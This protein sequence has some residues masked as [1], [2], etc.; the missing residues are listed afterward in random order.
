MISAYLKALSLIF[1]AEM[2]DKTQLMAM[3][4]A[5][6]YKVRD[7]L[8]GIGLGAF[9][10]HGLAILLGSFLQRVIPFEIIYLIAGVVFI[11]FG[12]LSLKIEDDEVEEKAIKYGPILT[13]SLAF[14]IGE[15]G[16][17]TQLTALTLST[18]QGYPAFILMGTVTGMVLTGLLGIW[19]GIKLG[20]KVPELQ[21]KLGAATI[22]MIFGI[23]KLYN[24][25]YFHEYQ[26]AFILV[27]VLAIVIYG[28][29]AQSFIANYKEAESVF[30][31]TAERLYRHFKVL[32]KGVDE[33]CLGKEVCKVCDGDSCLVGS[34]KVLIQMG[35]KHDYDKT[36]V[37][38]FEVEEQLIKKF[39]K[40]HIEELL[41]Y[42]EREILSD[43][44]LKDNP[45]ILE[46]RRLLQKAKEML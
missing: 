25:S 2:G 22:F 27:V 29:R 35:L 7:I 44:A 20:S 38:R 17:K 3:T 33:L 8:I 36:A 6:K 24:F 28:Y 18:S 23:E 45:F 40:E 14:F 31:E 12:L 4:F 32:E 42:I 26:W 39:N 16:D 34:L 15:L 1:L 46:I 30:A 19:V 5:T 10:N 21:L 9:F 11:L 43:E 13:V 37:K 41:T